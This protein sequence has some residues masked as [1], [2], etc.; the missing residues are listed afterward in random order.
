M[1]MF[2]KTLTA[3]LAVGTLGAGMFG[4]TAFNAGEASAAGWK[5]CKI[6]GYTWNGIPIKECWLG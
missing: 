6:I 2:K 1:K 4:A 3:V 5:N